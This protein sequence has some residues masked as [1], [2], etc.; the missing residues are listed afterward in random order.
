VTDPTIIAGTVTRITS[1]VLRRT[2]KL[3]AAGL[4]DLGEVPQDGDDEPQLHLQP[5][6]PGACPITVY[7]PQADTAILVLGPHRTDAE[8]W[9]PDPQSL[10]A[11]VRDWVDVV[12]RGSYQERVKFAGDNPLRAVMKG[13]TTDGRRMTYL[14]HTVNPFGYGPGWRAFTYDSYD[15]QGR[16]V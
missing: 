14:S 3:R 7:I 13:E 12:V 6:N 8:I 5:T 11:E 16:L 1:S 2:E 10:A 9:A 4:A 15:P